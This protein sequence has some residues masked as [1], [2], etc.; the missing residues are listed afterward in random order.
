MHA[1]DHS[2]YV[3][4]FARQFKAMMSLS[5]V[6][7]VMA[8][9]GI[10]RSVSDVMVDGIF[11]EKMSV[12]DVGKLVIKE[13]IDCLDNFK[14]DKDEKDEK[15]EKEAI[16]LHAYK[17]LVQLCIK[18]LIELNKINIIEAEY[19]TEIPE[20]TFQMAQSFMLIVVKIAIHD[21]SEEI[22]PWLKKSLISQDQNLPILL[23]WLPLLKT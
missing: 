13:C 7:N 19:I 10:E 15:D 6:A 4:M 22:A 14:K 20:A 16:M 11:E 12:F 18:F 8:E 2:V 5:V 21:E 23:G 3:D 1:I 9:I 17:M